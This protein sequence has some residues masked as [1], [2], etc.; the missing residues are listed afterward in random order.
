MKHLFSLMRSWPAALLVL[1]WLAGPAA[2]AQA[3]AWQTAFALWQSSAGDI[4]FDKLTTTD[5]AGNTYIVGQFRG[6]LAFGNTTLT[7]T[8]GYYDQFIAKWDPTRAAFAWARQ[9]HNGVTAIAT[10][11]NNL[12]LAGTFAGP[13]Y[14]LGGVTLTNVNAATSDLFLAKLVDGGTS[15][16]FAWAYRTGGVGSEVPTAVAAT[17]TSVFVTG[18]FSATASFGATSLTAAG[19]DD[20]FV[21]KCADAGSSAAFTWAQR[22]GGSGADAANGIAVV[23]SAIYV[24]GNFSSP[25]ADFGPV[26]LTNTGS[27]NGFVTKLT[28]LGSTSGFGW[29]QQAGSNGNATINSIVATGTSVYARGAGGSGTRLGPVVLANSGGFVAKLADNGASGSF[30]WAQQASGDPGRGEALAV[31]GNSVIIG[32]NFVSPTMTF[33]TITL[34]NTPASVTYSDAYVAKITDAGTTGT[35]AWARQIS[36]EGVETVFGLAVRGNTVYVAGNFFSPVVSFGSIQILNPS[37]LMRSYIA[38]ITDPTL[39]AATAARGTLSFS[40]SP[41]PARAAATVQLPAVPGA[42]T[43][44]LTLTDA[45]G[46]IV[47]TATLPAAGRRHELDL[48]GLAPGLYAVQVQ[49]GNTRGTQRLL[50]E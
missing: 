10:S 43:A 33:G 20:V 44:T 40:L 37:Y 35:F 41:N 2:R 5:A 49:A 3:P 15:S 42:P 1:W 24:G 36:G 38:T 14:D 30:V 21:L 31:Q 48:R 11:G 50:V 4:G 34:T 19:D 45:L 47:R 29:T 9:I 17:G 12:Y 25:T 8:S 28:D 18:Q 22:L 39:T 23:G 13:T 46:R 16:S 7:N 27:F 32:G 6:T 26:T